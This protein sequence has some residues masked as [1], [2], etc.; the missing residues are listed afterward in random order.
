VILVDD[1]LAY[2]AIVG[3]LPASL[4]EG[5]IAT[6]YGFHYRLVRALADPTVTGVLSREVDPQVAL[7]HV[8]TPPPGRLVVLD[9]RLG[10]G[11]AVAVAVRHSANLLLAELVGA[12]LTVDAPVRVTVAGARWAEVMAAEGVDFVVVTV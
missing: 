3:R 12:S 1:R 6:T 5:P 11:A 4:G 8:V 2:R 9:P 7:D 10:L